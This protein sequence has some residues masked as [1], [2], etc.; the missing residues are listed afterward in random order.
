MKFKRAKI[1]A[2]TG[3]ILCGSADTSTEENIAVDSILEL[4]GENRRELVRQELHGA[5]RIRVQRCSNCSLYFFDPAL[6]GSQASYE[7]LQSFKWYYLKDKVE[8]AMARKRIPP[9]ARV[10]EIGCGAGW[11]A[12]S[13]PECIYTGLEYSET[14]ATAARSAGLDVLTQSVY[15]HASTHRAAYQVVCTFQVLEHVSDP[16]AFLSACI[17]CLEPGGLLIHA[18]PSN[19]GYLKYLPNAFLNL[20]PHH[21]TR[22]PDRTLEALAGIYP[23]SLVALE[24][25]PL[26]AIHQRTCASAMIRRQF[27]RMLGRKPV[28]VDRSIGSRIT[29]R[30]ADLLALGVSPLLSEDAFRPKGHSVIATYRKLAPAARAVA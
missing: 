6:P 15:D 18:L 11:F 5:A 1:V 4:Y 22:W 28:F 13:I 7:R 3:C 30:C 12:R 8:Y 17:E 10:L 9:G 27:D 23:L 14:A 25:E 24:H 2:Q 29:G 19:E 21:L 26:A 16:A 20:P